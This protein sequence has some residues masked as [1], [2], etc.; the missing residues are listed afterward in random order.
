MDPDGARGSFPYDW[1]VP[2]VRPFLKWHRQR[3]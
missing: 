3:A 1:G 2:A